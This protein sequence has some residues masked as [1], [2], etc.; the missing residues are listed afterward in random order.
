M[1][2]KK[3]A[4]TE[5]TNINDHVNEFI[6]KHRKPLI[7][8]LIGIVGVVVVLIAVF[9]IRDTMISRAFSRVDEF[10]RRYQT[11]KDSYSEEQ[12][13]TILWSQDMD[14]L[15]DE[16]AQFV[17]RTSG[18]A[19]ARAYALYALIFEDQLDWAAAES[20]WVNAAKTASKTYFAPVAYFNAAVAAEEQGNQ[21]R[22]LELYDQALGFG[23][24]FPAAP[25]AQF[26]IGRIYE[27]MGDQFAAITA[28]QALVNLGSQDQ[29]WVNLAHSRI[30]V[31]TI[32]L[33]F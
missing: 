4:K 21:E 8:S 24:Q 10:E 26:S 18:F 27:S 17:K 5:K 1:P 6:Q 20:A 19:G 13:E 25:R 33:G 30:L 11:I 32:G 23:I 3:K 16:L 12:A 28:Y 9:T 31:L 15:M 14:T 2:A 7:F 22:A 29:I